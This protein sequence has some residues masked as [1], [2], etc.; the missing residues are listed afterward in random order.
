MTDDTVLASEVEEQP[1][2]EH[3]CICICTWMSHPCGC[4]CEH[5]ENC[6]C[7]TCTMPR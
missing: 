6:N 4:Y 1:C 2:G 3:H 7:D 5:V